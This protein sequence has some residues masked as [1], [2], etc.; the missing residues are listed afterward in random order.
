MYKK[1]KIC[2]FIGLKL[3]DLL[4]NNN[5]EEKYKSLINELINKIL[6]LH[7][8]YNVKAFITDCELG[9]NMWCGEIVVNFLK[10]S[11][12]EVYLYNILP[13]RNRE[14]NW[15][16]KYQIRYRNLIEN[17]NI[18]AYLGEKYTK[19]CFQMKE[20]LIIEHS[21]I[22]FAT[23]NLE[24]KNKMKRLLDLVLKKGKSL[25]LLDI[26]TLEYIEFY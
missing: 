5:G 8:N 25:I 9:T 11:C 26:K 24:N 20:K 22:I 12:R 7:F 21:D 23:C 17:C 14:K 2:G 19:K 15:N 6:E 13:F 3:N 16:S 10:N 18:T 1:I 4:E